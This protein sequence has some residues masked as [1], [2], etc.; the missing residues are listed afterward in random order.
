MS[1]NHSQYKY[2][3]KDIAHIATTAMTDRGLEPEFSKAVIQQLASI[4]SPGEDQ[5]PNTF[6]LTHLLWFS[7]DNDDSRDLDQLTVS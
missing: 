3:R 1:N 6:D 2:S 7:L 4:N 5:D